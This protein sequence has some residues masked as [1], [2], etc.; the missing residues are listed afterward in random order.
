[1]AAIATEVPPATNALQRVV[2]A[3]AGGVRKPAVELVQSQTVVVV[4]LSEVELRV[5][6]GIGRPQVCLS[7]S[8]M[9]NGL[10]LETNRMANERS[11]Q[12]HQRR[13]RPDPQQ[14][15]VCTW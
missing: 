9:A 7:V 14:Q 1:M 5:C 12:P 3:V 13:W 2:L 6:L 11:R 4:P 8:V 10:V 15:R